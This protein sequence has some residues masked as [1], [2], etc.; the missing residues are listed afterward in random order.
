MEEYFQGFSDMCEDELELVGFNSDSADCSP[1]K[2]DFGRTRVEVPI[3]SHLA[4]E[5][6]Q[7]SR[8]RVTVI[9]QRV[10]FYLQ[11]HAGVSVKATQES[12]ETKSRTYSV[13]I[14]TQGRKSDY[15]VRKLNLAYEFHS[16]SDMH[17]S[18]STTLSFKFDSV[19]PGH[20]LKG[21]RQWLVK[22]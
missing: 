2:L 20:G 14:M 8:A 7:F 21:R 13:K 12:E 5:V 17:L 15:T 6:S 11:T 18:L 1:C 4:V 19:E 10:I 9:I 22:P 16:I 3:G